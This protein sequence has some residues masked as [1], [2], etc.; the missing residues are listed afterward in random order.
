MRDKNPIETFVEDWKNECAKVKE[1]RSVYGPPKTLRFKV[2]VQFPDNTVRT[3]EF[4]GQCFGEGNDEAF[5]VLEVDCNGQLV[6]R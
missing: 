2:E 3:K 1:D 5:R 4:V 6:T